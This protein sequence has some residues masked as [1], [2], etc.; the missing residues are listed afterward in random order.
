MEISCPYCQSTEVVKHKWNVG[1]I[2]VFIL[3]VGFPLPFAAKKYHCFNC[4]QDFKK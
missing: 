1:V 4:D 2:A 3:L